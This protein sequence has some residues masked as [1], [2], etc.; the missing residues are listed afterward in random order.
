MVFDARVEADDR[1]DARLAGVFDLRPE[2]QVVRFDSLNLR[3]DGERF[4]LL[5]PATVSYADGYRVSNFLLV[6]DDQQ[7]AID[8]VVDPRGEQN[9]VATFDGL[10]LDGFTDLLGYGRSAERSTARST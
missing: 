8:G 7:I 2:A 1:R 4:R 3:L 10:R 9:L 6:S 5:L